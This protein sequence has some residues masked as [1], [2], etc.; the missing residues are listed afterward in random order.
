MQTNMKTFS[1]FMVTAKPLHTDS[2]TYLAFDGGEEASVWI[3]NKPFQV[4]FKSS[5]AE[6]NVTVCHCQQQL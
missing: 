3:T 5:G 4:K 1:V 2:K 6:T